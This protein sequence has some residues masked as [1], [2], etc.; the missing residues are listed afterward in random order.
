MQQTLSCV[1]NIAVIFL[2]HLTYRKSSKQLY[3]RSQIT[4]GL[5]RRGGGGGASN[6]ECFKNKLFLDYSWKNMN[7][8]QGL[9]R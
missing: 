5:N 3:Y 6:G 4:G 7:M 9:C 8:I 1:H 2:L